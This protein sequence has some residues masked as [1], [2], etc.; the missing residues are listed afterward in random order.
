[1]PELAIDAVAIMKFQ[2]NLC[3]VHSRHSGRARMRTLQRTQSNGQT[4]L[5]L[6]DAN[7]AKPL[8]RNGKAPALADAERV[9]DYPRSDRIASATGWAGFAVSP[10]Q[11]CLNLGR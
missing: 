3:Q 6:H 11:R 8:D 9:L 10:N 7:T 2:R 4:G 5:N 1:L